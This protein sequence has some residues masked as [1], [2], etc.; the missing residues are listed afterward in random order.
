MLEI[1]V[2]EKIICHKPTKNLLTEV[3]NTLWVYNPEYLTKLRLKKWIG[4]TQEKLTLFEINGD[5]LILPYGYLSRLLT[6]LKDNDISYSIIDKTGYNSL[7]LTLKQE[8]SLYDYQQVALNK[9]IHEQNGI[10]VSPT[11]SGKTRIGMALIAERKVKTLW[12]THTLD[13][14]N[15]SKRV[16]KEFFNNE[17]GEISGGKV[18]IKD[19][20]FA[21][22]QTLSS[23][24]LVQYK[25]TFDMTI[26][27]EAH[28]AI[29]SPTRVMMFYKIL[30]NLNAKFKY[31][32]TAT[33][34]E[35]KNTISMTP[36]FLLGEKIYEIDKN[37]IGGLVAEHRVY[38]L[39][40]PQSN[41]YIEPDRTINF[42][43]VIDY[44][45]NNEERNQE[46]LINLL[47][48][49]N[50][51]NL[52][53]TSRNEHVEKISE[54]LTNFNIKHDILIGNVKAKE[55]DRII[56]DFT[57]GKV[58]FLISNYQ[59]ASTGL[60]IPIANRLHLILP[61]SDKRNTIQSAGR[62]ERKHPL[63]K[64]AIIYDYVDYKIGVLLGMYKKRRRHLN[65]R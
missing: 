6:F 52:I 47:D 11:G 2:C 55:R 29:G 61:I 36:I 5:D 53:L 8:L 34:F 60:D 12:L 50:E 59:L 4:K 22:V 44:L 9:L 21:T 65:A 63:K 3:Q 41:L 1:T 40:T 54:L 26:V 37:E 23:I 35:T 48:N 7:K 39:D 28:K 10:L 13:L 14:L 25:D 20:T 38:N 49:A 42:N 31:G 15:Q 32:L 17:P 58:N 16:Y 30:S 45:I 33:L 19:V 18:N 62:I 27:D 46:I 64:D 56:K 51:Y 24:D 57:E 43:K